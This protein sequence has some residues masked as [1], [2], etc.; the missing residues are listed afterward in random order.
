MGS[1]TFLT[2]R[3]AGSVF[4]QLRFASSLGNRGK[5]LF[6]KTA[7]FRATVNL[8]IKQCL[9]SFRPE[10]CVRSL[11]T[12]LGPA[13]AMP[14]KASPSPCPQPNCPCP[15]PG[16][17]R[18][19]SCGPAA[20]LAFS[21]SQSGCGPPYQTHSLAHVPAPSLAWNGGTGS[22]QRDLLVG[23]SSFQSLT[24]RIV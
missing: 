15:C 16:T 22:G 3:R 4:G 14:C 17:V 5:K 7:V 11:A 10:K 8:D 23:V 24:H 12:L 6:W 21:S 2:C 20:G 9:V 19:Y 18:L 1:F 13:G